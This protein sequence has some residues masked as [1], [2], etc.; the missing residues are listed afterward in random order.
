[1]SK[2][3]QNVV[4]V[5]KQEPVKRQTKKSANKKASNNTKEK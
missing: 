2:Y 4:P 3:V 5:E 1:M